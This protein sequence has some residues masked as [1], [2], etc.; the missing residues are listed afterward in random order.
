V[1]D[2]A[3]NGRSLPEIDQISDIE[4]LNG[5]ASTLYGSD[6]IGGVVVIRAW[7]PAELVSQTS[8]NSFYKLRTGYDG[9]TTAKSLA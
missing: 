5:P 6:A 8:G 4:I 1:G 2:F 3:N 7:D 9:K